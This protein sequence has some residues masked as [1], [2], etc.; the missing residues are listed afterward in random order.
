MAQI[1]NGNREG[2][3]E[4]RKEFLRLFEVSHF[5]ARE[6]NANLVDEV[7]EAFEK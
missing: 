3:I 6:R 1:K 7:A 2:A 4:S 5:Q